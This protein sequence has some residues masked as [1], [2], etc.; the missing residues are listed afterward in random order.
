MWSVLFI[1]LVCIAIAVAFG[2]SRAIQLRQMARTLHLRYD[3]QVENLLTPLAAQKI[4]LLNRALYRFK[5]VLTWREPREFIRICEA[6]AFVPGERMPSQH[7]TLAAAELTG[8]TLP[9]FILQPRTQGDKN[10]AHPALPDELTARYTLSAPDNFQFPAAVL[11]MLKA[12]PLCY[13][14]ASPYALVYHTYQTVPVSE[15]QPMRLRVQQL[16]RA[17]TSFEPKPTTMTF[18]MASTLSLAELQAESLLKMHTPSQQ[19]P[20]TP[21]AMRYIYLA[22]GVGFVCTILWIAQHV[23]RNLVAK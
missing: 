12:G 13:V 3:A 17:L 22:F 14:E 1:V 11:G 7:Y 6:Y 18:R 5:Q 9:S 20:S 2:T 10:A 23:L 15:L 8:G 4:Y 19:T 16:L 21:G